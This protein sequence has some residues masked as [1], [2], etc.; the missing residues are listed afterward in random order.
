MK[1]HII[2][3]VCPRIGCANFFPSKCCLISSPWMYF[4]QYRR[5]LMSALANTPFLRNSMIAFKTQNPKSRITM[6]PKLKIGASIRNNKPIVGPFSSPSF[7]PNSVGR[8]LPSTRSMMC[9]LVGPYAHGLI[10]TVRI[11]K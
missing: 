1:W 8:S 4:G 7:L 10:Q 2:H 11:S 5:F 3:L 6:K 9:E